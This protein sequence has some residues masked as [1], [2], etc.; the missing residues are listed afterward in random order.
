MVRVVR[1]IVV[2]LGLFLGILKPQ[3][4]PILE[5]RLFRTDRA[6]HLSMEVANGVNEDVEEL[7]LSGNPVE[8]DVAIY[9]GNLDRITYSNILSYSPLKEEFTVYR[10]ATDTSHRTI[11]RE[12]AFSIFV[13][14]YDLY[15]C[16]VST[17]VGMKKMSVRIEAVIMLP[18]DSSFDALALWNYR[19]TEKAFNYSRITEI[20]F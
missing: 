8:I 13:S 6:I 2:S 1:T 16:P 11:S 10:S 3:T 15:I 20:P 4:D 9:C 12:A 14:F 18:E 7:V 19:T 17:F 5:C